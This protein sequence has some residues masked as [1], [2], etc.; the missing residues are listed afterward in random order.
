MFFCLAEKPT[1]QFHRKTARTD[2]APKLELDVQFRDIPNTRNENNKGKPINSLSKTTVVH[3][4]GVSVCNIMAVPTVNPRPNQFEKIQ[5][6][7]FDGGGHFFGRRSFYR[8][9]RS[10]N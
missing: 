3:F 8:S 7:Y 2:D 9:S 10:P 6:Y 4:R 1:Q 5:F